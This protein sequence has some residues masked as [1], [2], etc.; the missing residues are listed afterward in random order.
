MELIKPDGSK[1]EEKPDEKAPEQA[2]QEPAPAGESAEKAGAKPADPEPEPPFKFDFGRVGWMRVEVN[3]EACSYHQGLVDQY[4]GFM[5]RMKHQ[6]L[7]LIGR[8]A[9]QREA[10]MKT[11]TKQQNKNGFRGFLDGLRRR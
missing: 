7:T 10:V 1:F 4:S 3:L 6:G 9:A 2:A 8:L 5:D 11:L